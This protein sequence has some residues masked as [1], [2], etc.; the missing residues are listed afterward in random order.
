MLYVFALFGDI[1]LIRA[2]GIPLHSWPYSVAGLHPLCRQG[3]GRPS[4]PC[5]FLLF[6]GGTTYR[7]E[8]ERRRR[9]D[10]GRQRV[11]LRGRAAVKRGAFV[12]PQFPRLQSGVQSA[13]SRACCGLTI[14]HLHR[15]QR[16]ARRPADAQNAGFI[17]LVQRAAW[18]GVPNPSQT[19]K[20]ESHCSPCGG[21]P[22]SLSVPM[23]RL[24]S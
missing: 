20:L 16:R 7:E 15:A 22:V 10:G 9:V 24:D 21:V 8:P 3:R 1:L 4:G 5:H 13:I 12:E 17:S 23:E 6:R 2:S 14:S 11:W 19:A 18:R